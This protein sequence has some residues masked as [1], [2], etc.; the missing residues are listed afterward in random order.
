M[1]MRKQSQMVTW[2]GT[3]LP[4]Q[5]SIALTTATMIKLPVHMYFLQ[6]V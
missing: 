5:S 1:Q 6:V 4:G 2:I 3:S